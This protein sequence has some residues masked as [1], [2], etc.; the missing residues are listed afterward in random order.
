MRSRAGGP[1]ASLGGALRFLTLLPFPVRSTGAGADSSRWTSACFPVVG[2]L[3]GGVLWALLVLPLPTLSRGVLAV[4]AWT[5][6]TGALHEDGWADSLDAAFAPVSPARRAE[7]LGDPRVGTF[8]A[9]GLVLLVLLRLAGVV[10]VEP[11]AVVPALVAGRWAMV[12]VTVVTRPARDGGL[13][14][15]LFSTA[16]PGATTA[17][18]VAVLAGL[19]WVGVSSTALLAAWVAAGAGAGLAGR[20]LAGR[21]GGLTGDG[22]GAVGATAEVVALW[23]LHLLGA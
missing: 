17:V 4:T 19:A 20:F 23:T 18:T 8:G 11:I 10:G 21:L 15:W 2:L 13:G 14:A 1:L 5:L 3:L 9:V 12:A 7:I 22:L 16:R 6:L